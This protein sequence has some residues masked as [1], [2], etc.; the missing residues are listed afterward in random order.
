MMWGVRRGLFSNEAGQGSAP[1]AHAAAKTDEPVSEG[2]VALLEPFIDT[3]VICT[4]T[5][6]VIVITGVWHDPHPD[7]DRAR[8]RGPVL[9]RVGGR[10]RLRGAGRGPRTDRG[11]RRPHR[12]AAAGGPVV[13]WHEVPVERLFADADAD[14]AVH[15]DRVPGA[16]EAVAATGETYRLALRPRRRERRAADQAR[17]RCGPGRH[18]GRLHRGLQRAA[19]RHLDGDLVELLRGPLRPLPVRAQGGAAL[20]ARLRGHAL[21]RVRWWP[22]PPSGRSATSPWASSPSPT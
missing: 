19:V 10:G 12:G 6:L 1:I 4:M 21:R 14:H 7:R 8:R 11:A 18:L 17:L 9:P 15:R 16:Q 3:I 2:V 13:G 20:Q 22:W 5:G